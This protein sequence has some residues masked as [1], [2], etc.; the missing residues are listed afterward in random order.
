MLPND[1]IGVVVLT[2]S[3]SSLMGPVISY[4][5]STLLASSRSNWQE[6]YKS[7]YDAMQGGDKDAKAPSIVSQAH[8]CPVRSEE[9]A[10]TTN[11][12]YGN[13]V[14]LGADGKLSRASARSTCRWRIAFDVFDLEWR[15]LSEDFN[16]L[17]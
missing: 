9:Y 1:G 14:D 17:R 15:E 11:T 10:A 3:S 6:R 16:V 13:R 2:N 12:R 5:S 8:H 4:E 7:M